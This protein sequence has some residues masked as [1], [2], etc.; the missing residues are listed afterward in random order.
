M[1]LA[2]ERFP[3][4]PLMCCGCFSSDCFLVGIY[5]AAVRFF[6]P[7]ALPLHQVSRSRTQ[8]LSMAWAAVKLAQEQRKSAIG[9][10]Q[11]TMR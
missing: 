7:Y 2:V 9:N 10:A 4:L 5:R 11:V 8:H 1:Y 3:S 6:F